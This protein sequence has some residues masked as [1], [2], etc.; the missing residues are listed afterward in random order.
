MTVAVEIENRSGWLV[1]AAAA[2]VAVRAALAAEG[3]ADGDLGLTL[4]GPLEMAALNADHRGKD[5]PTDVLSFPL[6]GRDPL[7]VGANDLL[8]PT[9][10][11][12]LDYVARPA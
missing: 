2:A 10:L 1:D 8:L 7:P 6:D 5:E 12:S 11:N 9:A 4:V 3:V